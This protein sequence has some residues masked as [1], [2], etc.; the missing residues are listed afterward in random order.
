MPAET[1]ALPRVRLLGDGIVYAGPMR[2]GHTVRQSATLLCA[3]DGAPFTVDCEGQTVA[4]PALL[5][6]PMVRKAVLS[7]SRPMVL[8]D[9][10]PHH[11]HYRSFHGVP[12][13]GVQALPPPAAAR[14][15]D[16]AQRLSHGLLAGHA[17]DAQAHAIAQAVARSLPPPAP[18]DE[19]VRM[20]MALLDE[21]PGAELER[22]APHVGISPHHA[23]RLFNQGLGLS[24]RRYALSVK[25]RAA[26]SFMGSDLPL[27]QIAQAAGFVDSAH[28]ARVWMQCY[29]HAPSQFF[30]PDRVQLDSTDQ[31]DWLMWYLARRDRSLPSRGPDAQT[32]WI[33]RRAAPGA[34]RT[35]AA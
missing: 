22:L 14:F 31:P 16:L 9:L 27:T 5:V 21:D 17:L 19:R 35:D 32:P 26:A 10:E 24:M 3:V 34:V 13:P 28:F 7:G 1:A 12:H 6:R 11:A 20:L 8:I 4:A 30:Q 18:L 2:P 33:H 29:G 23:S 15:A 25:I